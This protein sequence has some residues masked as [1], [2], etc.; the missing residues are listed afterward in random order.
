MNE[1]PQ[2]PVNRGPGGPEHRPLARQRPAELNGPR[3]EQPRPTPPTYDQL[4]LRRL[5]LTE[6]AAWGQFLALDLRHALLRN[7]ITVLF[8]VQQLMGFSDETVNL[9]LPSEDYAR[10]LD[11]KHEEA[12]TRALAVTREVSRRRQLRLEQ[13]DQRD[14]PPTNSL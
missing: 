2:P 4:P 14:H 3:G 10:S 11:R 8:L 6:T 1:R 12:K 5:R 7:W 13:A 9:L